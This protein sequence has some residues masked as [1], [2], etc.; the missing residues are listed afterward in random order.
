[1]GAT[2]SEA[3]LAAA[4]ST[5]QML[6]DL[7]QHLGTEVPVYVILT[8]LDR[9]PNFTRIRP[10]SDNAK[11]H[12]SRFGMA[13]A[14]S[15][16][17]S[18]LYAEKAMGEVTSAL[19]QLIFS[20]GEFR[21]ELLAR[22]SDQRN[23]DPVYEF[24]REMRKLRNNLAAYLVELGPA[25]PSERQS[26]SE[27]LLLHRCSRAHGRADGERSG[28][29]TAGAAAEAGATRMFIVQQMQA[30]K[31]PA[32]AAGGVAESGAMVLSAEALPCRDP[33]GP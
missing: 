25:Q 12:P 21:L 18:G 2:A 15:E 9:I 10:Q 33:P 32:S 17:S 14:R 31:R 22:E 27:R 6:R 11:R 4:R 30:A 19:D 29:G 28:E 24:P 8:K 7:A 20:L 13:F 26:V 1:M 3:V 5:N 23:V 16:A